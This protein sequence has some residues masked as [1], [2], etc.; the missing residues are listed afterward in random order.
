MADEFLIAAFATGVNPANWTKLE[1][2]L[3]EDNDISLRA[4]EWTHEP[5]SKYIKLASGAI[6]GL[7]FPIVVW[8]FSNLRI[9][10]REALRDFCADLTSRVYI[11]TPTNETTNG[12]RVW[13]DYLCNLNWVQRAEILA[14][15]TDIAEKVELT[16]THCAVS[17][18]VPPIP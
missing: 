7:G 6:K 9:G 17:V 14:D 10:Q 15:G 8:Q 1:T 4:L 12:V 18:Y 2:L 11:R 16:F 13:A 5:Y 3:A